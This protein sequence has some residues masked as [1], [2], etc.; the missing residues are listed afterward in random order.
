MRDTV[1]DNRS[2]L[3]P[4]RA[5]V[6]ALI[7]VFNNVLASLGW[8][9]VIGL[10]AALGL[11]FGGVRLALLAATGF[12]SLGVLGLWDQS[13]AT[14]GMMLA[15][16]FIAVGIGLPLGT[17]A[18]RS[19]RVS[20]ILSPILDVMQIMPTLAYLTP[21]TLLFLIGATPSTIATL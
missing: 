3:E 1:G 12:A 9:G 6:A 20:A 18:G 10:A 16:V 11:A 5:T 17:I 2:I 13:M 19:D 4:I 8:P 15:A 14:L 21:I 7:D